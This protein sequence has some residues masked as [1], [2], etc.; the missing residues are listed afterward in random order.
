MADTRDQGSIWRKKDRFS[1]S[2]RRLFIGKEI[3]DGERPFSINITETALSSL[4]N[5]SWEK[6]I[7][8]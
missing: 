5:N 2:S 4:E 8:F 6:Q 3:E 7:L 1:I